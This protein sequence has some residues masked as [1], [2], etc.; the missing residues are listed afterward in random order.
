MLMKLE[1]FLALKQGDQFVVQY[2]GRFNHLT[3][4]AP[5]HVN[6]DRKKK[7]YFMRGLNSKIQTMM[8]SCL[9]AQSILPLLLKRSIV[10]TRRPRKRR[11][12]HLDL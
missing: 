12:C 1:E 6:S 10:S 2:V 4:Y 3:Q 11:M 8:T 7:A 5:D 9:N